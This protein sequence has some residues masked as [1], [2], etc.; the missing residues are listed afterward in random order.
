M[1]GCPLWR[2]VFFDPW[3]VIGCVHVSGLMDAALTMAAGGMAMRGPGPDQRAELCARW[4]PLVFPTLILPI[5]VRY[6]SSP[7]SRPDV[8]A[9]LGPL[10]QQTAPTGSLK[11]SPR[12]VIARIMRAILLASVISANC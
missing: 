3:G 7:S 5:T 2:K 10:D 8:P 6:E 11:L 1:C 9:R 4:T 12:V